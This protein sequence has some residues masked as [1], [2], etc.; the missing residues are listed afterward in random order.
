MA[1]VIGKKSNPNK[2]IVGHKMPDIIHNVLEFYDADKNLID[3][4]NLNSNVMRAEMVKIIFEA[5]DRKNNSGKKIYLDL[6]KSHLVYKFF[7]DV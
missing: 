3:E 5:F 4:Q 2:N 7:M 6:D 1:N